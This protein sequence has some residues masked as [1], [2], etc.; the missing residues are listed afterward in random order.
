[1]IDKK[2]WKGREVYV[3]NKYLLSIC[4]PTFNRSSYLNINLQYLSSQ[5]DINQVQIVISDNC[6]TDDTKSVVD[7]YNNLN[8]K[9]SKNKENFGLCDNIDLA[10]NQADGKYV[11]LMGDDDVLMNNSIPYVL[12]L[13]TSDNINLFFI[14]YKAYKSADSIEHKD[15]FKPEIVYENGRSMFYDVH[16][17]FQFLSSILASRVELTRVVEKYKSTSW[18]DR[19][20]MYVIDILSNGRSCWVKEAIVVFGY[21]D[22]KIKRAKYD[23]PTMMGRKHAKNHSTH[24]LDIFFINPNT[25]VTQGILNFGYKDKLLKKYKKYQDRRLVLMYLANKRGPD[26]EKYENDRLLDIF[27]AFFFNLDKFYFLLAYLT[28]RWGV[29][30]LW[31]LYVYIRNTL[32]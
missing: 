5:P 1:M 14:Q 11:W 9:Y 26:Y 12:K 10:I 20:I 16:V 32:K 29:E 23:K 25:F 6:S 24:W 28:P 19:H 7:K 18:Q 17:N 31:R 4:I 3:V 13:L 22:N 2:N 21:N 8:I 27:K 15:T 30:Y